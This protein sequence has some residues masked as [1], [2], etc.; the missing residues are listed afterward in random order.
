V[1][2]VSVLVLFALTSCTPGSA[3]PVV[4]F[5]PTATLAPETGTAPATPGSTPA[6]GGTFD[7]SGTETGTLTADPSKKNS[8]REPSAAS[9]PDW[10]RYDGQLEACLAVASNVAVLVMA[11]LNF[12]TG[13]DQEELRKLKEQVAEA[14]SQVPSDLEEDF[15]VLE[16]LL[17]DSDNVIGF[18]DEDF[19]DALE[20]IQ[21]WL[22]ENCAS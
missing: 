20:P 21:D 8:S 18:N 17:A 13:V 1:S 7:P 10:G 3:E 12:L 2:V 11:P 19:N 16:E 22:E 15:A 9:S 5:G 14:R 4:P 6:P